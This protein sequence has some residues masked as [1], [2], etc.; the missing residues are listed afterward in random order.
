MNIH[1]YDGKNTM[2][3]KI[4]RRHVAQILLLG[5]AG[6]GVSQILRKTSPIGRDVRSNE[7]AQAALQDKTSPSHEVA[8][9]TLTLV[10]F[11]DYRCPACRLSNA[12]MEAALLDDEHVRVVYRDWPIFGALSQRAAQ[13][14]IAADRQGIYPK[15]HSQLMNERRVL[16][17]DKLRQAVDNS[18]GTWAQIEND[19]QTHAADIERQ[20]DRNRQ[21]AFQLSISGTPTYLSGSILVSGAQDQAAFRKLFAAG[22]ATM[23]S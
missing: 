6:A 1:A 17:E 15:L 12:A 4:S 18:G 9:P 11:T 5:I 19:L 22:R 7:T 21:D 8:R 13:I 20:L 14:A 23:E 16:D 2:L 3:Q 10:L